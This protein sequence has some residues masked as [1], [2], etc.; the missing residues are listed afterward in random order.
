MSE[1]YKLIYG[2]K[3]IYNH[4]ELVPGYST[5]YFKIYKWRHERNWWIGLS[6]LCIWSMLWRSTGIINN[7]VKYLEQ[8][9]K[10][11]FSVLCQFSLPFYIFFVHKL[12]T[13]LKKKKKKKATSILLHY[14]RQHLAMFITSPSN[15]FVNLQNRS[16]HL[17]RRTVF[18]ATAL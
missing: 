10:P 8:R 1:S 13:P 17:D 7:Y 11:S 5:D 18:G 15:F 16:Y 3:N 6:N 9:E 2:I 4:K 12:D 14:H